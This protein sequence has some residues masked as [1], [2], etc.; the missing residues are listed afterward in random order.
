MGARLPILDDEQFVTKNSNT[1]NNPILKK[2][3]CIKS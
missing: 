2:N 1:E 3:L